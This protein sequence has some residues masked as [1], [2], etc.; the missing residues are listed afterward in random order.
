MHV[1][2][3]EEGRYQGEFAVLRPGAQHFRVT[4]HREGRGRDPGC[5][6]AVEE[7]DG[8]LRAERV[9]VPCERRRGIGA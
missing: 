8:G 2:P 7:G 1:L 5:P 4:A 3:V 9:G 6:G